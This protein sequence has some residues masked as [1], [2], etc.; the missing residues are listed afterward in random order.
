MSGV[1]IKKYGDPYHKNLIFGIFNE[2]FN[3]EEIT[4]SG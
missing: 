1:A 4:Q 3:K 2:L